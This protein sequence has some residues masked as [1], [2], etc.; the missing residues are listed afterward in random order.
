MTYKAILTENKKSTWSE[1]T[2]GSKRGGNAT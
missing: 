1:L 2:D